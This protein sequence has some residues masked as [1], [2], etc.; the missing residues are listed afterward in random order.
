[1]CLSTTAES[2][3][4]K[5]VAFYLTRYQK[6]RAESDLTLIG[7]HSPARPLYL[8]FNVSSHNNHEQLE[9]KKRER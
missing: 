5:A 4:L 3:T 1:M 9:G 6:E 8:F 7:G 2:S